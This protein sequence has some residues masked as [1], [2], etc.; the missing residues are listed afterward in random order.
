MKFSLLEM[1]LILF[2]AK[3]LIGVLTALL[4][5]LRAKADMAFIVISNALMTPPLILAYNISGL[6]GGFFSAISLIL[7]GA[8]IIILEGNIYKY[9]SKTT[10]KPFLLS[11]TA[12]LISYPLGLLILKLFLL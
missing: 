12:N 9:W 5:K 4:F 10:E 1:L 3:T 7:M 8:L 11:F 2:A 6:T